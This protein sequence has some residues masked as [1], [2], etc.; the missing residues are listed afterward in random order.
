[1]GLKAIYNLRCKNATELGWLSNIGPRGD[2]SPLLWVDP[3]EMLA[4]ST[5][6]GRP[7]TERQKLDSLA[8]MVKKYGVEVD[9]ATVIVEGQS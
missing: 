3:A 5:N 9:M 2:H 1:M 6:R 7:V 4:W 8:A